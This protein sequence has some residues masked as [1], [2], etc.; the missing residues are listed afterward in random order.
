MHEDLIE[1]KTRSRIEMEE[2]EKIEAD[3]GCHDWG[4]RFAIL[5][6]DVRNHV[7]FFDFSFGV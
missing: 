7:L 1:R 6:P 3:Q 4:S 2:R 5:I